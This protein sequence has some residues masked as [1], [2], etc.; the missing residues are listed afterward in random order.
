MA[1]VLHLKEDRYLPSNLYL[2]GIS[3]YCVIDDRSGDASL[4][5]MLSRL[6][7]DINELKRRLLTYSKG[8]KIPCYI[9]CDNFEGYLLTGLSEEP[10]RMRRIYLTE[11]YDEN[12][13]IFIPEGTKKSLY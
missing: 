7:M 3:C 1:I 4:L 2:N 10:I 9:P 13:L 11:D 8:A 5:V 6:E 12:S